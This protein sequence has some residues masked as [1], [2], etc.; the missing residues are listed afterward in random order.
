MGH[1]PT[2][3]KNFPEILK[4]IIFRKIKQDVVLSSYKH[5]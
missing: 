1:N 2:L 3:K 4:S 5:S